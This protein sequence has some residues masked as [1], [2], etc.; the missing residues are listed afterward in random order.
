MHSWLTLI[1]LAFIVYR[2]IAHVQAGDKKMKEAKEKVEIQELRLGVRLRGRPEPGEDTPEWAAPMTMAEMESLL[3]K[4]GDY[5]QNQQVEADLYVFAGLVD[6]MDD[7]YGES[8]IS[9]DELAYRCR[10]SEV[11]QWDGII[12]SFFTKVTASIAREG[13]LQARIRDFDQVKDLIH[14]CLFD[15]RE[16][17]TIC[18]D[19]VVREVLPATVAVL[20]FHVDG[21][22]Y[23][24]KRGHL[25]LWGRS[26]DELFR[27]AFRNVREHFPPTIQDVPA[28]RNVAIKVIGTNNHVNATYSLL[29]E[30]YPEL[31]GTH[32]SLLGI[33]IQSALLA[34]PINDPRVEDAILPMLADIL[35]FHRE[36][37]G[38]LSDK[39][40]WYRDGEYRELPYTVYGE[41]I[42]FRPPQEFIDM[43]LRLGAHGDWGAVS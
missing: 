35:G 25:Q 38:S 19:D 41:E 30:H 23:S 32:G 7:R 27:L 18:L 29:I 11:A 28:P 26:E 36:G 37:P 5:F 22:L 33:P 10:Q 43:V 14:V 8:K 6:A 3:E 21:C 17:Q 24:V 20:V 39:L 2:I 9:L 40:F 13:E 31:L 42:D 15:Q 4:V 34:Y 16:S 12:T 1:V